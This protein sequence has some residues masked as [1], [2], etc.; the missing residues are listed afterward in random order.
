MKCDSTESL[1]TGA[2]HLVDFLRGLRKFSQGLRF[3]AAKRTALCLES[4]RKKLPSGSSL[5]AL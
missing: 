4:Q 2:V 1:L 3:P 5:I